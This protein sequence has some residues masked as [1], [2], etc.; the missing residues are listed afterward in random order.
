MTPSP[1]PS[2]SQSVPAVGV[3]LGALLLLTGCKVPRFEGPQIQNPP[4][5]F[6]LRN[7]TFQERRMFQDRDIGFHT[8]W[9][10]TGVGTFSG[11]YVNEHSGVL[12]SAEVEAAREASIEATRDQRVEFG[13]LERL[14]IDGRTAWGWGETWRAA[15]GGLR[16]IALRVAVPYDSVTY[17][18]EILEG[19]P[20]VKL[21]PD[22][23]RTVASSFAIGKTE[24]NIPLIAVM[25]GLVLLLVNM[26]RSR[27]KA[28]AD[29]TRR[30]T[31]IQVPKKKE[32]EGAG[33]APSSA[34]SWK[35]PATVD[36]PEREDPPGA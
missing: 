28:R 29:A 1:F 16:Y 12:G 4:A 21:R 11:M 26:L 20:G 27:A 9:V 31:L 19:D 36:T 30:I 23:L 35:P 8:A 3:A 25:A 32:E 15:N 17:A 7:D 33:A 2:R 22:S 34:T 6:T 18:V 14:T 24:W 13:E 10:E 5:G